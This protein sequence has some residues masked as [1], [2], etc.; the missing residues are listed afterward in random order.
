MKHQLLV[1]MLLVFFI[2]L[3]A[4]KV[5]VITGRVVTSEGRPIQNVAVLAQMD[6]IIGSPTNDNGWY[7]FKVNATDSILISYSHPS[8]ETVY[9]KF[10]P[11]DTVRN[12][13]VLIEKENKIAE[14]VVKGQAVRV[15]D[16]SVVYLPTQKQKNNSNSGLSLLYK[17]MLP[18][19]N[20]NPFTDN[21]SAT[22]G[23]NVSFYIDGRKTNLSEIKEIR[24]KD[25]I[26]VELHNNAFEMFPNE[27]KVINFV[28]RQYDYG[29]YVDIKTDN[30]L[31]YNSHEQRAQA[32]F[33]SKKW[34]YTLAAG[35]TNIRDNGKTASTED[36]FRFASP[37]ERTTI[38]ADGKTKNDGYSGSFRSSYKGKSLFFYSQIG[39]DM[40]KSAL[41]NFGK[42]IYLPDR[43]ASSESSMLYDCKIVSP[44]LNVYL[45]K[46]I[47]LKRSFEIN[48]SSSYQNQ[49]YKRIYTEQESLTDNNVKESAYVIKGTMKWKQI[50]NKHNS[51]NLFLWDVFRHNNDE[52]SGTDAN[53]QNLETNSLLFYPTYS[54]NTG[55]LYLSCQAGFNLSYTN[56]NKVSY[57]KIYP[58]PALTVNY[59]ISKKRSIYMDV[60]MGSTEPLLSMMNTAEQRLNHFQIVKGNPD[61]KA[62]K[63][64]D[65]LLSYNIHSNDLQ[66][67]AFFSY[68]A[69]YDLSKTSYST[70][71]NDLF[72]QSYLTDGNFN[73]CTFGV[74]ATFYCFDR[75]LQIG[76]NLA[77]KDQAITGKDNCHAQNFMYN[78]KLAD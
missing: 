60:R 19:L 18:E 36:T 57:T 58:R 16:N 21:V 23:T 65:G 66:M 33:D 75:S 29:G 62:M 6:R 53:R 20:V 2:D 44:S 48:I 35:A 3:S 42:V 4:Q 17:I 26:R 11:T 70:E 25:V 38:I 40:N 71:G 51:V 46:N 54:Y 28:V 76:C 67:S 10:L 72:V 45:K 34:N 7:F 9:M 13:V 59:Y 32:H 43:Y 69:L 61:L 14:V 77:Y 78:L 12:D 22:D 56:V 47:G 49:K 74:N 68:N 30:R 55:K 37:F 5:T 73:S 1:F 15:S 39:I 24:P 50:F 27:Q 8:Y 31:F 52:Y 63:I 64:L 41:S